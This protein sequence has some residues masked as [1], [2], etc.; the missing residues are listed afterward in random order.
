M[1]K[2]KTSGNT[3]EWIVSVKA[4]GLQLRPKALC[5]KFHLIFIGY[6]NQNA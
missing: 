4:S 3:L 5:L 6:L 1:G 2:K